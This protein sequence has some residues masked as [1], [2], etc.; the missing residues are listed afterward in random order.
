[1][2]APACRAFPPQHLLP[3]ALLPRFRD[4]LLEAAKSTAEGSLATRSWHGD[5]TKDK[6]SIICSN[7]AL[8]D[9]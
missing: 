9:T 3:A 8:S 1:M 7:P 5:R 6:E 4:L 2:A